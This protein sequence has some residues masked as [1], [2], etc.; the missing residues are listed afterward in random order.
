MR[1]QFAF[2]LQCDIRQR[3]KFCLISDRNQMRFFVSTE[4][5]DS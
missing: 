3:E 2:E 5:F 1:G 4:T